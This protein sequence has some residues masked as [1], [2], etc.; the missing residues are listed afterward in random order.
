MY[1]YVRAENSV[2]SDGLGRK[3]CRVFVICEEVRGF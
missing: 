3:G 1:L 2:W